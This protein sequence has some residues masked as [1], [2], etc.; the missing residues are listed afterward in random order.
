MAEEFE[1]RA[2]GPVQVVHQ[3][4]KWYLRGK[5]LQE[6]GN[7]AQHPLARVFALRQGRG[8]EPFR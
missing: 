7:G 6:A 5:G 1:A 4:R 2:I 3:Q 8:R